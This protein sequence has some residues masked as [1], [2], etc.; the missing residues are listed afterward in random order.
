MNMSNLIRQGPILQEEKNRRNNLGLCHYCGEPGHIAIDHRNLALLAT[1]KQAS[2][3][4][5]GNLMTLVPYKP[6][7]MEE[8]ETSLG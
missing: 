7:P 2:G 4:F 5:T 1:N 8:K 6:L 3:A